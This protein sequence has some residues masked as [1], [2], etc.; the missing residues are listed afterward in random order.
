[1]LI[2]Q[3]QTRTQE[4]AWCPL[5][6]APPWGAS[7]WKIH[8]PRVE[9]DPATVGFGVLCACEKHGGSFSRMVL[10]A[11]QA[12]QVSRAGGQA[13]CLSFPAL[14]TL[15]IHCAFWEGIGILR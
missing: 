4:K 3:S 15:Y 5:S 9:E 2:T 14:P 13:L 10:V 8:V 1:M 6:T 7:F 12:E 11:T